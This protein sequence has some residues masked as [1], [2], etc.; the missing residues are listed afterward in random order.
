MTTKNQE[1]PA[2]MSV[3]DI[4]EMFGVNRATVHDWIS[5]GKLPGSFKSSK[6]ATSAYLV[7]VEAVEALKKER[8]QS[9][10]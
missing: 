10:N 6:R 3:T 2:Y 8:D 5:A 4:A 9:A 7:P 1:Q